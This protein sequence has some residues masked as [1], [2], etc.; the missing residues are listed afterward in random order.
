MDFFTELLLIAAGHDAVMVVVDKF[1][2]QA[3][4]ISFRKNFTAKDAARHYVNHVARLHG[5]PK[6]VISDRDSKFTSEFWVELLRIWDVRLRMS[7]AW[8]PQ[9]DGQSERVIQIMEHMLRCF[10]AYQQ[11]K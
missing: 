8:H 6:S 10:V 2:K 7:S 4:F 5:L 11:D 3:H 9:T 1:S